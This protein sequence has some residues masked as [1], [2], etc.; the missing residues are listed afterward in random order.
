VIGYLPATTT[1]DA[2]PV[3]VIGAHYDHLGYGES[4]SLA[5]KGEEGQI[6]N[7][8]DD[9]ASGTATLL[10]IADAMSALQTSEPGKFPYGIVFAAWSGEELGIIGSNYWSRNPTI[11]IER[12]VAYLNFDMVGR[13][14][15]NTLLL[16]GIGSSD[17][18]TAYIEKRNVVSGFDLKLQEDPYLPTDVTAFYPKGVPVIAFF[19]GSHQDY[20]RPS[21]DAATLN[22]QG[23]ERIASFAMNLVLDMMATGEPLAYVKV[24]MS[25]EHAGSRSAMRVFLGTIPD[26]A[27]GD[28]E[29]VKLS[30]VRA[31]GPADK[32]GLRGG[33]VIVELA[34]KTIAN[35]YDYTYALDA[36]KIGEPAPVVVLRDGER[37]TLTIVPESRQ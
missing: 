35:I 7:G 6:H 14:K 10:E 2:A 20:H 12:V 24:A 33:D 4:G 36:L 19:T 28:I 23:M 16:Q 37:V 21:D 9:N 8:A 17:A 18:W 25:D 3:I 31:D 27:E 15:D 26:Y 22:Y 5:R 13:L 30:G 34:G 11:P 29:G 1:D 32:A